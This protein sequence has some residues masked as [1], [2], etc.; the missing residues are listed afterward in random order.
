MTTTNDDRQGDGAMAR[1]ITIRDVLDWEWERGWPLLERDDPLV[2][3]LRRKLVAEGRWA[4]FPLLPCRVCG[5][6]KMAT[7]FRRDRRCVNRHG[8]AHTCIACKGVRDEP[9]A[10]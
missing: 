5:K 10:E 3:A 2:E 8:R 7:E 6:T 1:E 4:D 9:A